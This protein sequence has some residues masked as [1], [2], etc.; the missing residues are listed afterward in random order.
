MQYKLTEGDKLICVNRLGFD[1]IFVGGSAEIEGWIL[2][3]PDGLD[4]GW[5]D[6][7]ALDCRHKKQ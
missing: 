4:D 1:A 7:S 6:G 3:C 2:G 5:E